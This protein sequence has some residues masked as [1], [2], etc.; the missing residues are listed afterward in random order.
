MRI[1]I[2]SLGAGNV[3]RCHYKQGHGH[4]LLSIHLDYGTSI[5]LMSSDGQLLINSKD[6]EDI[7][8][9]SAVQTRIAIFSFL[10][11]TELPFNHAKIRNCTMPR[12]G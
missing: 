7:M 2:R 4:G 8:N 6:P 11:A 10:H 9:W 1:R 3:S 5:S 12:A